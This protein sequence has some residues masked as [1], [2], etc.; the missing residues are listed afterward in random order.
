MDGGT[1]RIS[2]EGYSVTDDE[3]LYLQALCDGPKRPAEIATELAESGAIATELAP[4]PSEG[5]HRAETVADRLAYLTEYAGTEHLVE[6]HGDVFAL[7][8][9]GRAIF[10]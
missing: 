8:D 7:T 2:P 5:P 10:Y 9:D 1:E 6:R 3:R 4:D